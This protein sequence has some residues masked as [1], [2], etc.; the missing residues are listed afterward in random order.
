MAHITAL[1]DDPEARDDSLLCKD[2]LVNELQFSLYNDFFELTPYFTSSTLD[3]PSLKKLIPREVAH[4][5][6]LHDL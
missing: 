3:V 1:V 5:M 4:E 2:S 6:E